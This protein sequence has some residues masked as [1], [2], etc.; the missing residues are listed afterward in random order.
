[1]ESPGMLRIW[2]RVEPSAIFHA[3]ILKFTILEL[4]LSALLFF[5]ILYHVFGAR[6]VPY[7]NNF[8]FL[9]FMFFLC[10]V[11]GYIGTFMIG[12]GIDLS[13]LGIAKWKKMF[14]GMVLFYCI[15]L[16]ADSERKIFNMLN[17]II[18]AVF[19]LDLFGL[20]RYLFFG[21][22]VMP[23]IGKVVFWETSKFEMNV[24]VFVC[25][26]GFLLLD[27]RR[28]SVRLKTFY[29]MALPLALAIVFMSS[30]RTSMVMVLLSTCIYLFIA[31]K[32]GHLFKVF[33]LLL[34]G[35]IAVIIVGSLNYNTFKTKFIGRLESIEAVFN[36]SS[37]EKN[38]GHL[39]ASNAS[40]AVHLNEFKVGWDTV[41]KY[42]IWGV[43]YTF[44]TTTSLQGT[45]YMAERFWVHNEFLTFW[46][47]FGIMGAITYLFAYATILIVLYKAYRRY[48]NII[49]L[50]L[51]I[52]F[53]NKFLAGLFFPPF[54]NSFKKSTLFFGPL[55]IGNAYISFLRLKVKQI[56]QE[57]Q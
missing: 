5:S 20:T 1:M 31:A 14:Y 55:A 37:L 57:T 15:A 44:E 28:L 36:P 34:F 33:F 4:I 54:I 11:W 24:F 42:P 50:T 26:M 6:S 22:F 30:R 38:K 10:I 2:Q 53:L 17:A 32:Q 18:T 39:S 48:D 27:S 13:Q 9:I 56:S 12:R 7:R 47:R 25:M 51:L 45:H 16:Y 40:T 23:G 21:G 43:G 46:M 29:W 49:L 3:S 19:L 8:R 52:W 35:I 41:K